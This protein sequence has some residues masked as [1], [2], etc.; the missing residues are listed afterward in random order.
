MTS[1]LILFGIESAAD[2]WTTF[3]GIRFGAKEAWIPKYLFAITGVY[4]GLLILKGGAVAFVWW[5]IYMEQLTVTFMAVVDV[6]YACL[7]VS[8][9]I[10][11]QK[12][13]AIK[14]G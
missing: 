13:K 6:G 14:N 5:L 7:V 4:Y 9:F 1:I 2:A 10:Q 8:N 3:Q 11:L 12:Q